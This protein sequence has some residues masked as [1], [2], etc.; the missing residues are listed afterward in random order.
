MPSFSMWIL[1]EFKPC[2]EGYRLRVTEGVDDD[3]DESL[4]L[5]FPATR[6]GV[7]YAINQLMVSGVGAED[8]SDIWRALHPLVEALLPSD[9]LNNRAFIIEQLYTEQLC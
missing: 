9:P 1:Q 4:E 2:D 5:V 6:E 3:P 8:V 7:R